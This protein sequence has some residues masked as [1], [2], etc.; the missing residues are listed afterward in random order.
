[1]HQYTNLKVIHGS[2]KGLPLKALF[3]TKSI[4]NT[5]LNTTKHEHE[6]DIRDSFNLET[7]SFT[8][9]RHK[10]G[11]LLNVKDEYLKLHK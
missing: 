6:R 2:F 9:L 7:S 5:H 1:M 3:Y 4:Y 10:L 11:Y 8:V